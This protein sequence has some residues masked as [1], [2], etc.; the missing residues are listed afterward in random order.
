MRKRQFDN[1][2]N[3]IMRSPDGRPIFRNPKDKLKM[4]SIIIKISK[5]IGVGV[6]AYNL[7]TNCAICTGDD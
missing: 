4:L 1:V 7:L 3:V 5:K 6:C 2:M